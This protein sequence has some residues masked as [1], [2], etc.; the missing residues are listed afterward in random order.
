MRLYEN[1]AKKSIDFY[2]TFGE[3]EKEFK[4]NYKAN[5]DFYEI[6]K[7]KEYNVKYKEFNGGHTF[8]DID[9]ELGDGI[10]HLLSSSFCKTPK[11]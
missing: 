4:R 11:L 5:Q 2:L 9:M 10:I 1:G 8:I 6:L 7:N 3:F